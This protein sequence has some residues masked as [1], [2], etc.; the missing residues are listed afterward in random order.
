MQMAVI[1]FFALAVLS[2]I[3]VYIAEP[4]IYAKELSLESTADNPYP[5]PVTLSLIPILGLIALLVAGVARRWRWAF[6]LILAALASSLIH[7]PV[8]AL[9]LAGAVSG[10]PPIWY[11]ICQIGLGIIQ[12]VIAAGMV[13][14]YHRYGVWAAG[15]SHGAAT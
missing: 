11:G 1:G 13:C 4:S 8:T 5:L 2:L 3:A 9:Q 6:W 12:L 10:G 7:I 15:R 14:L